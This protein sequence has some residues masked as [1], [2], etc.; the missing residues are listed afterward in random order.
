MK[1]PLYAH[2]IETGIVKLV[3]LD[4]GAQLYKHLC[5]FTKRDTIEIKYS[6][7]TVCLISTDEK[8]CARY[9]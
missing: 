5:K 9:F 6:D 1:Y 4:K 8:V 3:Y 7:R 2:Y